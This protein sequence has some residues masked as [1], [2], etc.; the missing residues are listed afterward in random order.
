MGTAKDDRQECLSHGN[1]QKRQTR[2][3]VAREQPEGCRGEC[4][5]RNWFAGFIKTG[6]GRVD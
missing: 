3:S 2:V 4:L 6:G 5:L 1:N